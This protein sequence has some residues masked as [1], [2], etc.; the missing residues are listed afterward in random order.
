VEEAK[1]LLSVG[2][3]YIAEKDGIMLFRRPKRFSTLGT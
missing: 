2:F 1:K 3:D